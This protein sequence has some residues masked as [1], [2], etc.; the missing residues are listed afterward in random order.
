MNTA[1]VISRV[2]NLF[3]D[4]N[5]VLATT[6][7]VVDLI[8]DGQ[9]YIAIETHYKQGSSAV[10]SASSFRGGYSS[11]TNAIIFESVTYGDTVGEDIL[12]Q[13]VDE[14]TISR[15]GLINV[16]DGTPEFYYL[17]GQTIYLFPEPLS[18]DTTN[19][20]VKYISLP[21]SLADE[22]ATLDIPAVFHGDLCNFILMRLH[23]LNENFRAAEYYQ[24][25][26]N[27]SIGERKFNL[28]SGDDSFRQIQPDPMDIGFDFAYYD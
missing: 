25:K 23:E 16:P 5:N 17:D 8:N 21:T 11:I 20:L 15:L 3:G 26:F 6:A 13:L 22:N 7:K 24:D 27:R 10:A 18:T 9:E 14:E 28:L 2:K 1:G 19:V 12:L 4:S